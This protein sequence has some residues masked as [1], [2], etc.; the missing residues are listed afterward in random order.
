MV[1]IVSSPKRD[2]EW[3]SSRDYYCI[4][5]II[6]PIDFERRNLAN[7]YVSCRLYY[8]M[9]F[10][11]YF[12]KIMVNFQMILRFLLLTPTLNDLLLQ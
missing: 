11:L 3:S 12:L 8:R 5:T 1:S 6:P 2:K 7:I 9:I 4:Y 10:Q